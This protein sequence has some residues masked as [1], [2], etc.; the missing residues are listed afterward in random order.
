M[1]FTAGSS[2]FAVSGAPLDRDAVVAQAGLDYHATQNLTLGIS[3]TAQA[4]A[5]AY[6]NGV[7]GLIEYKF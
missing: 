6:D 5:R 1:A 2:A 3:Y 7:K 4:G